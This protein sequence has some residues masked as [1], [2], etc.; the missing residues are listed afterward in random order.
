MILFIYFFFGKFGNTE[1]VS[2]NISKLVKVVKCKIE[3]LL[4]DVESV[5][6]TFAVRI[7]RFINFT[8]L[9]QS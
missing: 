2:G 7:S 3:T 4:V 5:V 1:F 6:R 8:A 9:R